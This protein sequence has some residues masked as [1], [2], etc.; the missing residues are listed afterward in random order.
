M[1]IDAAATEPVFGGV[2]HQ[3]KPLSGALNNP[4]PCTRLWGGKLSPSPG[5]E[6]S[7]IR[8]LTH[9]GVPQK[10]VGWDGPDGSAGSGPKLPHQVNDLSDSPSVAPYRDELRSVDF[11]QTPNGNSLLAWKRRLDILLGVWP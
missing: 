5:R 9:D 1:R 7:G 8:F 6:Q 10:P 3:P 4:R 2:R 11:T